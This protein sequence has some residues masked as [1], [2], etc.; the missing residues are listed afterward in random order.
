MIIRVARVAST[1]TGWRKSA[2]A[3]PVQHMNGK[4]NNN[5]GDNAPGR[6]PNTPAR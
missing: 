2:T 6:H 1:S 3:P 5:T 4:K